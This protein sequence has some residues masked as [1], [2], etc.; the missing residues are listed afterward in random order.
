[1]GVGRPAKKR[2]EYGEQ[3]LTYGE[4]AEILTLSTPAVTA[5]YVKGMRTITEMKEYRV[6]LGKGFCVGR[7]TQHRTSKGM[8]NVT[9]MSRVHPHGLSDK[10]L[11]YRGKRWGFDHLCMWMGKKGVR[12]EFDKEATELDGPPRGVHADRTSEYAP[13]KEE[14]FDRFKTCYRDKG[15]IRCT[16]YD[17]RLK[18]DYD[19]PDECKV[20]GLRYC[21]NF[22]GMPL[23]NVPK[24]VNI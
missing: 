20:A 13:V 10:T 15:Q 8:M 21:T 19:V 4:A 24:Q 3:V 1:M 7:G 23:T 17:E 9:D 2:I 5:M 18:M 22:N 11:T 14:V 16:I 12:E 6:A